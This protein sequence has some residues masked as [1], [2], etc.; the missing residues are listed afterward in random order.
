MRSFN[1][2]HSTFNIQHSTFNIQLSTF[3]F[4]LS[5][6]STFNLFASLPGTVE[7]LTT[8]PS[9]LLVCAP[10]SPN[11][12]LPSRRARPCC[13]RPASWTAVAER[14]PRGR[15]PLRTP[16]ALNQLLKKAQLFA[17][18]TFRN[19]WSFVHHS[20]PLNSRARASRPPAWQAHKT[21]P[22]AHSSAPKPGRRASRY[23]SRY[24]T[25]SFLN[26][27]FCYEL[28][29][30]CVLHV[31]CCMLNVESGMLNVEC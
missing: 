22:H 19:C 10:L 3:N 5:T 17:G 15:H 31:A 16:R 24:R 2:Q 18:P 1:I 14:R 6:S 25:V 30:S 12:S 4:Q 9:T 23:P 26:S 21:H 8:E 20:S 13:S 28:D 29:I 27:F 7:P 11:A